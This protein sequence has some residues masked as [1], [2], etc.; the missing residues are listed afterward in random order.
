MHL[1]QASKPWFFTTDLTFSSLNI[2]KT[3]HVEGIQL[4]RSFWKVRNMNI[5]ITSCSLP[6]V[7]IEVI[8]PAMSELNDT[9]SGN[10]TQVNEGEINDKEKSNHI[11]IR[12]SNIGQLI[13]KGRHQIVISRCSFYTWKKIRFDF[14]IMAEDSSIL[15]EYS[16]FTEF[17]VPRLLFAIDKAQNVTL[18]NANFTNNEH[19]K[20]L[21]TIGSK[22]VQVLNVNFEDNF[23]VSTDERCILLY[24]TADLVRIENS[25]FISNIEIPGGIVATYSSDTIDVHGNTFVNNTVI[26]SKIYS[27]RI[28]SM[29]GTRHE[30]DVT[31]NS[32][33]LNRGCILGIMDTLNHRFSSNL[34]YENSVL[35]STLIVY[36]NTVDVIFVSNNITMN[37]AVQDK[38]GHSALI[39]L[40]GPDAHQFKSSTLVSDTLFQGNSFGRIL[41][42][43]HTIIHIRNTMILSN[44]NTLAC[45]WLQRNSKLF[46]EGT[47]VIL[48]R[49]NILLVMDHS[50]ATLEST[51]FTQ[52]QLL[53]SSLPASDPK[54]KIIEGSV[55]EIDNCTFW[56]NAGNLINIDN[57][58][59]LQI[60]NTYL[61]HNKGQYI[62]FSNNSTVQFFTVDFHG[63]KASEK[64]IITVKNSHLL[65]DA[66]MLM[67]N[68]PEQGL[69]MSTT[70]NIFI[71]NC[72][73][74]VHLRMGQVMILWT[75]FQI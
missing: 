52:T 47:S 37:K 74:R 50:E 13:V 70:S 36:W 4:G 75:C 32:F 22:E 73:L 53:D 26:S 46:I 20:Q 38:A 14:I 55:L 3:L 15:I 63:N 59:I 8:G 5:N 11:N 62:I 45:F 29:A 17:K 42:S 51:L 18:R 16:S 25:T 66:T 49:G 34:L 60:N 44:V 71:I 48:N 64:G 7:S 61:Y 72:N 56:A 33:L 19:P 6:H 2:T 69:I 9:L 41:M 30:V 54:L 24:M 40:F 43:T 10:E 1:F 12:E 28:L 21:I 35:A 67:H 58:A 27:S 68:T 31:N 57:K 65:C 39:M 23:C